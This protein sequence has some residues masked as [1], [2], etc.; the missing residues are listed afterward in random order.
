MQ[1]VGALVMRGN[2][3][4]HTTTRCNTHACS[5]WERWWCAATHCNILHF[6]APHIHTHT[7]SASKRW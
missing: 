7:C 5:V 2:S 1:R 3:L 6:T 4:Q